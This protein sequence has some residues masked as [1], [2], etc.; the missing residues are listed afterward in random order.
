MAAHLRKFIVCSLCLCALQVQA[1]RWKRAVRL[2]RG[3]VSTLRPVF[4]SAGCVCFAFS[5]VSS[6]QQVVLKG[7][8]KKLSLLG[9]SWSNWEEEKTPVGSS[10]NGMNMASLQDNGAKL[11]GGNYA[12]AATFRNKFSAPNDPLLLCNLLGKQ[13][14]VFHRGRCRRCP[15][16]GRKMLRACH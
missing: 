9:V 5:P 8:G 13:G 3:N 2:Q 6:C 1:T 15:I 11:M 14:S 12:A 7:A 16:T 10:S 4:P